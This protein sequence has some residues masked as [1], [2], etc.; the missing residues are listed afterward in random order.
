MAFHEHP[1]RP[2]GIIYPSRLNGETNLAIYDRAIGKLTTRSTGPL[3][4]QHG[5]ALVLRD[6]NVGLR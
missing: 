5:L 2:D 6:L 1:T 4:R 3:L